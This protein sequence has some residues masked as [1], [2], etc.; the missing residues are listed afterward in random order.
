ME[1]RHYLAMGYPVSRNKRN[2]NNERKSIKTSLSKYTSELDT[3]P[4][5]AQT[6][7]VSGQKHLFLKFQKYSETGAGEKRK[8]FA[9]V[10]LSGGPL[11]DLGNFASPERYSDDSKNIGHVSG[12]II[13]RMSNEKVLVAI[14]IREIVAAIRLIGKP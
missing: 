9:P 10:G 14:R 3:D 7:G 2:V 5:I 13:E 8:T 6:Y 1:D 4:T 11:I 12:M